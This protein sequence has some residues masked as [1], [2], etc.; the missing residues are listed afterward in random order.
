MKSQRTA[1]EGRGEMLVVVLDDGEE[2]FSALQAFAR[3]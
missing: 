3:R 2:A 1:E